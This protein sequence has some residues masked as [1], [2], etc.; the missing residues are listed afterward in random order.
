MDG[1]QEEGE[2]QM[3]ESSSESVAFNGEMMK[4]DGDDIDSSDEEGQ[5]NKQ[6]LK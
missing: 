1:E 5:R 2:S 3:S 6:L 4:P